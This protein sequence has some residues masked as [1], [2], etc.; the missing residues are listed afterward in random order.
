M[1]KTKPTTLAARRKAMT[2]LVAALRTAAEKAKVVRWMLQNDKFELESLFV[3]RVASDLLSHANGAADA[4][5][6]AE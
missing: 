4:L 6:G 5:Y 1:K 2:E 3:A